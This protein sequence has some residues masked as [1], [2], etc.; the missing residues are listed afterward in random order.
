[1]Q[2]SMQ[3]VSRH[4]RMEALVMMQEASRPLGR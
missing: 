4:T 3:K 1:M 2:D